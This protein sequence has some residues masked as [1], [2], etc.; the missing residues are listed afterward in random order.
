[1]IRLSRIL[2]LNLQT[3][4][5][6]DEIDALPKII[7]DNKP[8]SS[9]SILLAEK[10][11]I[12]LTEFNDQETINK[13]HCT[14]LF[15]LPCISTWLSVRELFSQTSSVYCSIFSRKM[16]HVQHAVVKWR[17]INLKHWQICPS[18]KSQLNWR[19]NWIPGD[20]LLPFVRLDRHSSVQNFMKERER[21]SFVCIPLLVWCW[22][23]ARISVIYLLI[24]VLASL[25]F[26]AFFECW[27]FWD[28]III[29]I[30]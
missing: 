29:L 1:M 17:L 23:F 19:T 26:S 22:F 8:T 28:I 7:F 12:C 13:L 5:S 11:P 10:C 2:N 20:R 3:R 4:L 16:I 27:I 25:F 21:E 18:L 15:H 14:H 30:V 24:L 6:Q 9:S